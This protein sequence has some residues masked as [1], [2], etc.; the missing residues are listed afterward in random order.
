MRCQQFAVGEDLVDWAVCDH[1]PA[2]HYDPAVTQLSRIRQVMGNDEHRR[3]QPQKRL[4]QFTSGHWVE[5]DLPVKM[6]FQK[7]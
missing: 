6:K 7:T 2:I 5:G 3:V 1:H 4:G